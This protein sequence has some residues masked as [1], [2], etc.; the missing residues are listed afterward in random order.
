MPVSVRC[1]R[2]STSMRALHACSRALT[3]LTCAAAA[4][5]RGPMHLLEDKLTL[6]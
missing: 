1:Q 6:C 2:V 4:A 5:H 3:A